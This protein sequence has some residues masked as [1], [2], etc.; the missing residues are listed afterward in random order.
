VPI[1]IASAFADFAPT[2]AASTTSLPETRQRSIAK[3]AMSLARVMAARMHNLRAEI[4]H[5]DHIEFVSS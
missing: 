1:V 4:R 3:I 5:A 2:A